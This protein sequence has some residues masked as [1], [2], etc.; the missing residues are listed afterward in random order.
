MDREERVLLV[1]TNIIIEAVRTGCWNALTGYYS[2][3]TVVECR[4]EARS[5]DAFRP[6]YITVSD[7]DLGRMHDVVDV[8]ATDRAKLSLAYETAD[9]L[10]L[11]ERDLLAHALGR[12]DNWQL[13]CSDRAAVIAAL[14]L[15]WEQ[16]LVTLEALL[17]PTG[18]QPELKRHY[19][20]AWLRGVRTDWRLRVARF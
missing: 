13:S 6:N 17:V 19:R 12:E 8:S 7:K 4:S 15:S 18:A 1:D 11:G 10:D 20:D 16:R 2:V 5:G 3:V 14:T 9:A